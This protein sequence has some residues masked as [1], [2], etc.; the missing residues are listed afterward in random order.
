M[1]NKWGLKKMNS[2][3]ISERIKEIRELNNQ[4]NELIN[5]RFTWMAVVEGLIINAYVILWNEYIE[6]S[7]QYKSYLIAL[8][9]LSALGF[10]ISLSFDNTFRI[11]RNSLTKLKTR[12]R[13]LIKILKLRTQ[14]INEYP[15]A[16]GL[17]S[18][19]NDMRILDHK[20]YLNEKW[21]DPWI[22]LPKIFMGVWGFFLILALCY[23][24]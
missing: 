20:N 24:F 17:Y 15:I 5:N 2:R 19:T 11:A 3:I 6:T 7:E 21:L 22:L 13:K 10:L 9:I 23:F 8:I 18:D 16:I 12:Y 14:N 4:E 1:K